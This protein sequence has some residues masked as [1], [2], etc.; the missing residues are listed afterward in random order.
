MKLLRICA[1]ITMLFSLHSVYA[2]AKCQI[3]TVIKPDGDRLLV[4][5]VEA[6]NHKDDDI[7]FHI[8]KSVEQESGN[9]DVSDTLSKGKEAYEF[10]R[11][12]EAIS[13]LT[14]AISSLQ[15]H[16]NSQAMLKDLQEA[17]LYLAMSYLAMD[18]FKDAQKAVD[19]YLC[20]S[21]KTT[22]NPD[23]WPPNLINLI[24]DRATVLEN[25]LIPVTF[26]TDPSQA[27]LT[28]DGNSYGITPVQARLL[29]CPHYLNVTKDGYISKQKNF[30]VAPDNRT[31]HIQLTLDPLLITDDIVKKEQI[32]YLLKQYQTDSLLILS[33]VQTPAKGIIIN[34]T[35]TS[36]EPL[37]TSTFVL[38]YKDKEQA[39][40]GLLSFLE[41]S[42][43]VEGHNELLKTDTQPH[44]PVQSKEKS[45]TW[46]K[47][48]WLWATGAA[49]IAGGIVYVTTQNNNHSSSSTG[50]ISIK[51]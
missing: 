27:N 38:E 12:E 23:L 44:T 8:Y 34:A 24:K 14:K 28:I 20:M 39:V 2:Q 10:L 30:M 48:K 21:G 22:L 32:N 16:L 37:S 13:L 1:F 6:L 45:S 9:I 5:I 46:Y 3:L 29:P 47:N 31:I 18:R 40:S 19:D 15:L 51:W 4:E 17:E 11:F 26:T 49:I 35:Y 33:S 36:G 42:Q 25:N 43:K 50:S 41:P 7:S